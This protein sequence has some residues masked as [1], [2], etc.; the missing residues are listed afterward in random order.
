MKIGT[1]LAKAFVGTIKPSKQSKLEIS[2]EANWLA[3][4]ARPFPKIETK[5]KNEKFS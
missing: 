5:Q 3:R 4:F 1:L 2:K